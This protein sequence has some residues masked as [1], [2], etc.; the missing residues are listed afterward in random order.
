M[1]AGLTVNVDFTYTEGGALTISVGDF[2]G[3]LDP[4]ATLILPDGREIVDDDSGPGD[5]VV[6]VFSADNP[7]PAGKYRLVV[8]GQGGT[9]GLFSV[10]A[11]PVAVPQRD[12]TNLIGFGQRIEGTI[13]NFIDLHIYRFYAQVGDYIEVYLTDKESALDPFLTLTGPAGFNA[14][15]D[16]DRGPDDDALIVAGTATI[17]GLYT[18]TVSAAP[19][20]IGVGPYV[21]VLASNIVNERVI[22]LGETVSGSI[23]AAGQTDL[24]AFTNPG[25]GTVTFNLDDF[26]PL[27]SA[28]GTLDPFLT[29]VS[30]GQ[31]VATDENSG[32]DDD[33]FITTAVTEGTIMVTGGPRKTT[34]PYRLTYSVGP[35]TPP[36]LEI[37]E[38]RTFV[39]AG[40]VERYTFTAVAG[41]RV[42][43]TVGDLGGPLDPAVRLIGPD[44]SVV[45]ESL[46]AFPFPEDDA[47]IALR[48]LEITGV[49]TVEVFGEDATF[50]RAVITFQLL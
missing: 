45:V 26:D 9:A 10:I 32:P 44:G 50:G 23:S 41:Q 46:T 39:F 6:I 34:G 24:Y 30:G 27:F 42:T 35:Y 48:V 14:L 15:T 11:Q 29:L 43:I 36:E 28:G 1:F 8:R 5:D 18:I 20:T 13:R 19:G 37:G 22:S 40:D 7:A 12:R 31:A 4:A 33:A 21:L 47:Q 16:D 17:P 3:A 49:Y 25:G 2:G 38:N